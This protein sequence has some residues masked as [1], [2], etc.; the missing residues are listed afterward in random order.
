MVRVRT[1][2]HSCHQLPS[3]EY[4]EE[5]T[6]QG[7]KQWGKSSPWSQAQGQWAK[8][9]LWLFQGRGEQV[10]KGRQNKGWSLAGRYPQQWCWSSHG[11]K[12]NQWLQHKQKAGRQQWGWAGKGWNQ[13]KEESEESSY[14]Q[15][16]EGDYA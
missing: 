7:V 6:A 5:G 15:D 4:C 16:S 13:R 2:R 3:W 11:I 8:C 10:C 12:N 14:S 1:L 9:Y